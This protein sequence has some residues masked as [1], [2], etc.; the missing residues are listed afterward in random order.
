MIDQ[1][2]HGNAIET[3]SAH[4]EGRSVVTERCISTLKNKVYK[5]MTSPSTN[6]NVNKLDD[7][8]DKC[9]HTYHR[10]IK[11]KLLDVRLN[12][13][14]DFNKKNK[15]EGPKFKVGDHV[16]ISKYKNIF[17]KGHVP[18][19]CGKVFLVKKS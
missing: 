9:N 18:D 17:A 11:M 14:I 12:T 19:W 13:Y 8:V 15:K 6:V 16:R 3:Y 10:T 1:W 2:N 7:V 4:N 5:Y